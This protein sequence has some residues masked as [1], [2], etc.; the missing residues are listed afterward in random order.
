[1]N[2][3][4]NNRKKKI[5][6]KRKSNRTSNINSKTSNINSKTS[7][8]K[9][10][11]NKQIN[12][13]QTLKK[14]NKGRK[15][16]SD[17]NNIN[18][19]KKS[20]KKITYKSKDSSK[21]IGGNREKSIMNINKVIETFLGTSNSGETYNYDKDGDDTLSKNKGRCKCMDYEIMH[22]GQIVL[23]K[24]KRCNRKALN[25]KD[26]C[27]LHKKC[28]SFLQ[29]YSNGN[30]PVYN[31]SE[32]NNPYIKGSHNCYSYFLNDRKLELYNKCQTY[33]L[34]KHKKGCP[35]QTKECSKLKP[36]PGK[37]SKK[38]KD[39]DKKYAKSDYRCQNM[40]KR[41]MADNPD[42]IKSKF[43]A[44]C[45]NR[46]YK[47]AMVVDPGHT[48]HFYR[49][50]P[51][52]TWSHKPGTLS[53][54]DKDASNNNIYIPHYADRDYTKKGKTEASNSNIKY[55]DFCGYYCVP[56]NKHVTTNSI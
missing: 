33:C 9:P 12:N 36:Q 6:K 5:N 28:V 27:E 23:N 32:W 25:G 21:K 47:G 49:K 43:T 54:T 11:T 18:N 56:G 35:K 30:E 31:L 50:K 14:E 4:V 22:T 37:F 7:M 3:K 39:D 44:K 51:D 15:V 41:I 45:P 8:K 13:K 20:S 1:M 19:N 17:R 55:S 52:G 38:L 42:I 26:F 10:K 40:E 16:R 24:E 2:G 46:Y 29:K 48:F 53:V 34:K